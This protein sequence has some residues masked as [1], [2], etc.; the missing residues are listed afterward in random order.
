MT[1]CCFDKTGTLTSDDI[2]LQGVVLPDPPPPSTGTTSTAGG[3]GGEAGPPPGVPPMR[4]DVGALP[5]RVQQVMAGCQSLVTVEGQL[6]GDPLE[7]AA[8]T[9]T[10][11]C[12]VWE[13]VHGVYG[14]YAMWMF[15]GLFPYA[16]H[17]LFPCALHT[18][19]PYLFLCILI[20]LLLY[21]TPYISSC[22]PS[23]WK[24]VGTSITSP[25]G[26][27]QQ[28]L[29]ILHRFAFSSSLK[30]MSVIVKVCVFGDVL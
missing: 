16:L 19:S 28:T 29:T 30:R 20:L 26:Q 13:G 23:G 7:R 12:G 3:G 15:K 10:G 22:A 24:I 1:V 18:L 11:V 17:I 6:V 2:L 5:T 14:R 21:T 8:L 25:P 4:S 9:A 27:P